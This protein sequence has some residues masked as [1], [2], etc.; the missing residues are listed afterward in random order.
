[1][2]NANVTQSEELCMTGKELTRLCVASG[3][4]DSEISD[5][6]EDRGWAW[7]RYKPQYLRDRVQFCLNPKEMADLLE[8]LG[9]G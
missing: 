9:A 6:M 4:N 7:Y 5:A 3:L 2:L 1:M 8:V